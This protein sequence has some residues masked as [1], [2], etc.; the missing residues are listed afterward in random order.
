MKKCAELMGVLFMAASAWGQVAPQTIRLV[1]GWN[2]FYLHVDPGMTAIDFFDAWPVGSVSLYDSASFLRTAQYSTDV[3]T[4][5]TL[6]PAY[7]VWRRG[8]D[9]VSTLKNMAGDR[10][11][12]CFASNHFVTTVYGTPCVQRMAWHVATTGASETPLNFFGV[13]M[14]NG[15][16]IP[17]ADYLQGLAT[18]YTI[19]NRVVGG[20]PAQMGLLVATS[21]K[22]GAVL[23][24]DSTQIDDW[25][26]PLY[27]SPVGGVHFGAEGSLAGFSVRNDAPT[28]RTVSIAYARSQGTNVLL[29]PPLLEM[30][31]KT[32]SNTWESVPPVMTKTLAAGE[33]W[34]LVLA[35]D[36]TQFGGVASA[37]RAGILT[38]GD[39]DG[40]SYFRARAPVSAIGAAIDPEKEAWP[41]G[42]WL[43]DL[44]MN[45]VSQVKSAAEIED[46]VAS[47][48]TMPLRAI[49]HV[50]ANG[51]MTL[52][53]R[54]LIATS[55]DG[56]GA[57]HVALHLSDASVPAGASLMR[58]STV[59]MGV[60]N[61]QVAPDSGTFRQQ[62]QFSFV[63]AA[64]D[65]S[66]PF[67]HATHP[68]HDGLRWD[69]ATP[70]PSGD[71]PS[72][73]VGTVKP[74]TFSVS[75][76]LSLT[77]SGDAADIAVWDP[78]EKLRGTC[79]WSL[80]GLRR[81]GT[82]HVDGTFTMQRISTVGALAP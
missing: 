41:S 45:Q 12:V 63:V 77:W 3:A 53:Q 31:F 66:N 55:V 11:Y 65:R 82:I 27:L 79:R 22:D 81:E 78:A 30:L 16:S 4:E 29:E 2:A 13:S 6:A 23:V 70:A 40:G 57:A 73:Y 10:I 74:E 35:I 32:S 54:V 24:M 56:D 20:N 76:V 75:N 21:V 44:R 19:T 62:A 33:T 9:D 46:G 37:K 36:R 18:G 59:D 72:N 15:V 34:T 7:L 60:D 48:G 28:N 68:D 49:L 1:N 51:D 26:G 17:T 42:L 69:F 14:M 61:L 47:G 5:P 25:A 8:L 43:V 39:L 64:G 67:R 58:L 71:D 50:D 52:L 38:V 80:D